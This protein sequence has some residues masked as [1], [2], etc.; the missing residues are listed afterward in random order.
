MKQF[1]TFHSYCIVLLAIA[2]TSVTYGQ[3]VTEKQAP[4]T[5]EQLRTAIL[6]VLQ[7]TGTPA[8]G[9]AMVKKEG[10]VWV[11]GLGMADIAKGT[12]ADQETMF[13]IG[14][15]SKIFAALAILKLQ[16]QGKLS[17][18]DKV[19]DLVPEIEF[20]NPWETTN[21]VLVEHL[22][23]HTTGWD[24]IHLAELI[25]N[26]P[27]ISLKEGLDFHPHSRTSKWIPG[28]RMAY[29]NSGPA[30]AAY[31]V[32]KISGRTYEDYIEK[33][34]F[35]PMGM[36]TMTY[37]LSEDYK[38]Q[39]AT[40]YKEGGYPQKYWHLITRPSG[41]INASPKDMAKLLQLFINRGKV[42]DKQL[43]SDGS[44]KRMET[45]STTSGAKAGLKYGYGLGLYTSDYNG[46]TYYK[47]GGSIGAGKSDF[48]YLPEYGVGYS[49]QTNSDNV[50][51][52]RKIGA[53]IREY[54]TSQ[55][56][57]PAT[58]ITSSGSGAFTKPV[59]GYYQQ[60][61]P[62]KQ[63]PFKLPPLL[64][65]RIWSEGDTIYNQFPAHVGQIVKFV[66]AEKGLYHNLHT[67]R[68]DFVVVND[69]LEGEIL[70][71]AGTESG[72]V[73]LG[74][75]P[76][77]LVFGRITVLILWIIFIIRAGVLLPFWAY[78]YWKGK[79]PGGANV[80]IRIWPL[81]PVVF[82]AIAAVF[83]GFGAMEGKVLLAK[84]SFISIIVML[85]TIAFFAS[86]VLTVV[87]AIIY[88]NKGIRRSVYLPATLLSVL[89]LLVAFYLLWYG[90]IGL[91]TWA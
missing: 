48:S 69:P 27:N 35:S 4:K 49:V 57:K 53:L 50:A 81:L 90:V 42:N 16:E 40:L 2:F 61:N 85:A 86:A 87:M 51:A 22:L 7:E 19:R 23:E 76:G 75:V 59:D 58:A 5:I 63:L 34:F 77:V 18:K 62:I 60:I 89:H 26:D 65:E 72:T 8:A 29:V 66:P 44:V 43:I 52:I 1:I 45:P 15:T 73:T 9:I 64:A 25:H 70:E 31:I 6:Q 24:D 21:P 84:P 12:K 32:E 38:Q 68:P 78:R 14:S 20:N 10:P 28:T 54:Q 79:I 17:L 47:H 13:R 36:E 46:Y 67:G 30:V 80:L 82:L 74:S 83:L 37:F 11:E 91:R 33:N 55:L 3:S 88:R 56:P 41:A 39:G 71:L